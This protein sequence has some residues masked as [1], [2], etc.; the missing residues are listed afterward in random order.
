MLLVRKMRRDDAGQALLMVI[1]MMLIMALLITV[2]VSSAIFGISF[3]SQTRASVASMAAAEAGIDEVAATVMSGQCATIANSSGVV[4]KTTGD[5]AYQAT[6]YKQATPASTFVAGCPSNSD[7]SFK[8]VSTG[9]AKQV[10][11]NGFDDGDD[12]TL[13]GQWQTVIQPPIFDDAV[14]GDVYVGSAGI[15]GIMAPD[16]DASIYTEGD[17]LCPAGIEIEGSVVASRDVTFT[18]SNCIVTGDLFAGRDLI[19]PV[20][21]NATPSVGGNLTV[22]GHIKSSAG[23][24]VGNFQQYNNNQYINVAGTVKAGGLIHAYCSYPQHVNNT[25]WTGYTGWLGNDCSNTGTRA[26]MRVPGLTLPPQKPWVTVMPDHPMFD[27]WAT[28]PWANM[29]AAD[30]GSRSEGRYVNGGTCEGHPWNGNAV[31]NVTQNT[32]IDTRSE[33]VNGFSLG[34]YATMTINMSADL[35]IF[36]NYFTGSGNFTINSTDGQKHTL[37]LIDP[38]AS[39]SFNDC[40]A[41]VGDPSTANGGFLFSWGVWTQHPKIAV[42]AYTPGTFKSARANFQFGGQVYSCRS[43]FESGFW[44]DFRRAGDENATA[45][46]SN[47]KM[48]YLRQG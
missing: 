6:V 37:Y 10:G 41:T 36:A 25:D 35:V 16:K 13:E 21:P 44:L 17:F 1:G 30:A 28:I 40:P 29:T 45:S 4:N 22:V 7:H 18:Q 15:A 32:V 14:R 9:Y 47:F 48:S 11:G 23:Q 38:P 12:V 33:C 24:T 20:A 3:T 5:P 43:I 39:A 27:G 26:A 31:L 34:T 19:Y 46:L 42:L 2:I 8:I